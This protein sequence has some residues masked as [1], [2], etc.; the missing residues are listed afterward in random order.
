MPSSRF[1]PRGAASLVVNYTG[2][3]K[4][5]YFL[6][7]PRVTMLAF[8]SAVEPLRVANQVSGRE[9]YRWYVLSEDGA[10]VRCSNG[11]AIAP[12]TA[13]QD[14]PKEA[15]AFV[16]AGTE[17]IESLSSK[18]VQWISRQRRVGCTVGGIC[19]GAFVLA[20]AELLKGQK[21]TLHWENQP[22]F[23]EHFFGLEPEQTLYEIEDQV[24]GL[25]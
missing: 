23:R 14:V 2:P 16:C 17:P 4:D 5:F 3:P 7:L 25:K 1:V 13:L 10:P 9:L 22:A 6:L 12:D 24:V 21:F 20:Q 8:S 19:T 18:A 15:L 11:I